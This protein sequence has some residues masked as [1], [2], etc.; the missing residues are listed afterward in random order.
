MMASRIV[1][2]IRGRYLEVCGYGRWLVCG[3]GCW[4]VCEPLGSTRVILGIIGG[5]MGRA[6]VSFLGVVSSPPGPTSLCLLR[7]VDAEGTGLKVEFDGSRSH[8]RCVKGGD[9]MEP[10]PPFLFL[11]SPCPADIRRTSLHRTQR[12][13]RPKR[14]TELTRIMTM[15]RHMSCALPPSRIWYKEAPYHQRLAA[16]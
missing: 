4:L 14:R 16:A 9:R 12:P 2:W 7:E 10:F 3:Y 11:M 13:V 8:L 1:V 15:S 6:V 5:L